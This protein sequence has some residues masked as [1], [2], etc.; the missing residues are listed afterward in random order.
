MLSPRLYKSSHVYNFFM[1]SLGY[2]SS[3]SRF[4]ESVPLDLQGHDPVRILDAGC[5]TGML[6]LHFLQRFPKSELVATD[7]EPNFL[8]ATLVNARSR[9]IDERRIRVGVA[10]ISSPHQIRT[11]DQQSVTMDDEAFS[12]ICVGAVLGYADDIEAAVRHLIRMLKPGGT[13][14]NI[15][16]NESPTGRFVARRYHYRNIPLSRMQEVI[17]AEGCDVTSTNLSILHLPAKFTRT[18]IIAR[19]P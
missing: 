15:E 2:E 12:I 18:T 3:I 8:Q 4:L 1:K 5:G 9:G 11:T 10:N 7:L 6:G 14:I 17:R 16:M 19:K 13:L